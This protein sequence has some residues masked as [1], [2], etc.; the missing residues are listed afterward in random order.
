MTLVGCSQRGVVS[1]GCAPLYQVGAGW[2]ARHPPLATG[3]LSS[4]CSASLFC[5]PSIPCLSPVRPL[6]LPLFC[7]PSASLSCPC[8]ARFPPLLLS[9]ACC[10]R[11]WL[12]LIGLRAAPFLLGGLL[13]LWFLCGRLCFLCGWFLCGRLRAI[14]V[15]PEGDGECRCYR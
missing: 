11:L 13:A 10:S 12:S 1:C 8:V 5:L 2:A 6:P 14:R 9:L 4:A 3:P 7:L 15:R